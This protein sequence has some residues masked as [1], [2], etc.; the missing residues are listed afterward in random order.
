MRTQLPEGI[1]KYTQMSAKKG[2]KKFGGLAEE[3][4]LAEFA[5][6]EHY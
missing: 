3:A 4:L 6:L 1:N 2:I 5:Q